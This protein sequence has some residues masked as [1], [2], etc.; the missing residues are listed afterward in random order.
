MGT[1]GYDSITQVCFTLSSA[2]TFSHSDMVTDSEVFYI[3]LF[4]VLDDI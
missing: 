2:S 1:D 4:D 3:S